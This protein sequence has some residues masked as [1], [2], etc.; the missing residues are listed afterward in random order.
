MDGGKW[1]LRFEKERN[2]LFPLGCA[3]TIQWEEIGCKEKAHEMGSFNIRFTH[4]LLSMDYNFFEL[5]VVSIV[6]SNFFFS[7]YSF[8]ASTSP[9]FVQVTSSSKDS[10]LKCFSV[11]SSTKNPK[12]LNQKEK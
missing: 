5:N 9:H 2:A 1:N 3:K 12:K 7:N 6:I 4:P 11:N 10:S 8:L